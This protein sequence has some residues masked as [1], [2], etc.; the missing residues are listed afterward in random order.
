VRV[1][2]RIVPLAAAFLALA[3]GCGGDGGGNGG[4]EPLTAAELREQ[5]D[6][7]CA[8]YNQRVQD[9]P[10]PEGVDDLPQYIDEV[11]PIIEEGQDELRELEPPEELEADWDRAMS[12][13]ERNI[14]FI[15]EPR[16]AAEENDEERAQQLFQQL[17]ETET[18]SDQIARDLGLKECGAEGDEP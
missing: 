16:D 12:L 5:A 15:R 9:V 8:E 14:S 3:A 17:D 2:R 4:G 7:I 6:A 18:E 1:T 13:N 10:E 11:L